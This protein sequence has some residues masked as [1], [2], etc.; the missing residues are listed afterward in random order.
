L[1]KHRNWLMGFGIGIILGAC[2]LQLMNFAQAQDAALSVSDAKTYTQVQLDAEVAKALAA[3]AALNDAQP[4]PTAS[5]SPAPGKEP[6]PSAPSAKGDAAE[7]VV[8]IDVT[9]GMYLTDVADKLQKL[10]VILNASDFVEKA[11]A[12]SNN[13]QVGTSTFRGKPSYKQI[14][15]ELTRTKNK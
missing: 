7:R 4:K 11:S 10:G 1:R 13:L 12:I 9:E 8:V 14:I 2:M 15:A 6:I 3:A 5:A